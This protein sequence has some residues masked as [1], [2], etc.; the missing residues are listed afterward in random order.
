[1]RKLATTAFSFAAAVFAAQY[2][3]APG[4]QLL[5][6]AIMA[7]SALLAVFLRGPARVRVVL[8]ALSLC[9]GFIYNFAYTA[10]VRNDIDAL[11]DRERTAMM[12]LCE[13]AEET[14]YGARVT[15]KLIG[16]DGGRK[17]VYYGSEELLLLSPGAQVCDTVLLSDAGNIRGERVTS[18]TSKGVHLL[19]YSRGEAVFDEGNEGALRYLPQRISHCISEAL[20]EL[21]EGDTLALARSLVLGER[22]G[23]SEAAYA[24]LTETSLY[25][26]TAVSGMHCAFLLALTQ[27]LVGRH[28][29][30]LLAAVSVPVLLIYVVMVGAGPSVVRAAVMLI[31]LL[32]EPL[33]GRER[34]GLTALSFAL[35][36]ILLQNPYAAASVGLQLSFAAVGGMLLLTA[37][38]Y[39]AMI[40]GKKHIR[41]YRFAAASFSASLG[42][43]VFTI[44]LS[45]YYF[46]IL[47]IVAPLSNLLCLWAVSFA[48]PLVLL[49][50][51][52]ASVFL[53]LGQLLSLPAVP[54]LDY[55]LKG[56]N[57]LANIPYHALYFSNEFL[58]LW[59]IFVYAMLAVCI[60]TRAR[61]RGWLMAVTLG[62]VSLAAVVMLNGKVYTTQKMNV[63][64][65]D[66]GQGE[67][68]IVASGEDAVLID[69]GSS[70]GFIS[71]GETAA[72]MLMSMGHDVLDAAV[73]SHY[74]A[75]H[76]NG[77]DEL[78][79]RVRIETLVLADIPD[80]G[81]L[82]E[83]LETLAAEHDTEII[84]VRE[85]TALAVGEAEVCV[86][87]PMGED[88][89]NEAC[90][91]V[92][93]DAGDFETLITGDMDISA[94]E[95]LTERVELPDIEVILAGHHGAK[96][97]SSMELLRETTPETAVIS[98]GSNSYGHPTE[99]ALIRLAAVGAQVYR[100]D[101]HG[102]ITI[103][104]N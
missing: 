48:F 26:I 20:G 96:N 14:E 35:L 56:A 59:L 49:S 43:M 1:M 101:L 70:N 82:R 57:I 93:C 5:A 86:Y 69:C 10:L 28:R 44:P 32:L 37:R 98:V 84:Y 41:A 15:V 8:I 64:V 61:A 95:A 68:V 27:M 34:D 89:A 24:D 66:V 87:P 52:A 76:A 11:V 55:V 100:T 103:S 50:G 83:E 40:G 78:F 47:A 9:F 23:L 38:V 22:N 4:E 36:L 90:L 62:A 25:H 72:D 73:V 33:F 65:L 58:V 91:S 29:R 67:S 97:A 79:A 16:E 46:N 81:D 18:F 74:H 80:E 94:E 21:Y 88:G 39:R 99:E 75:D 6:A 45:A 51:L 71:A 77:F 2:F 63:I 42:S 85:M 19:A 7:A 102:H 17:A 104:V 60:L 54:L 12:E 31:L 53:P 13:Y 30:R 92:L 3:L